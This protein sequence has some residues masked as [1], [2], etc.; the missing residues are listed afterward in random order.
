MRKRVIRVTAL[1]FLLSPCSSATL[2][3]HTL[4]H[5]A[6]KMIYSRSGAP[7]ARGTFYTDKD[8][9]GLK[10]NGYLLHLQISIRAALTLVPAS[11]HGVILM[12]LL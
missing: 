10:S 2:N 5:V 3:P 12:R 6:M 4:S 8:V 7:Y 11:N 9:T 1:T